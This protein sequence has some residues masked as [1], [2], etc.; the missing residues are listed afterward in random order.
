MPVQFGTLTV[1]R[2]VADHDGWDS[3][4]DQAIRSPQFA[5]CSH[6]GFDPIPLTLQVKKNVRTWLR[7]GKRVT[8][9]GFLLKERA[10]EIHLPGARNEWLDVVRTRGCDSAAGL[11]RFREE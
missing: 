2:V 5:V 4:F 11:L 7:S 8:T 3:R 9:L 6:R 1:V 10:G